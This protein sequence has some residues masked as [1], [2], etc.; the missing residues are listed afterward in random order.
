MPF[1][2]KGFTPDVTVLPPSEGGGGTPRVTINIE[3]VARPQPARQRAR[4]WPWVLLFLALAAAAG[5]AQPPIAYEQYQ[6]R[7]W[8]GETMR[9]GTTT[10]TRLYREDGTTLLHCH[11]YMVGSSRYTQCDP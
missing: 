2:P 8:H 7:D 11:S 5:H 1:D 4:I 9:Q 10:D 6:G 3:I